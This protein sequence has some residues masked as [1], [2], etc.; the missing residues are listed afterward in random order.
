MNDIVEIPDFRDES[1]SNSEYNLTDII[2]LVPIY[3][4]LKSAYSYEKI[5]IKS[6]EVNSALRMI[7]IIKDYTGIY[8]YACVNQNESEKNLWFGKKECTIGDTVI[9]F[10]FFAFYNYGSYSHM[11]GKDTL[12]NRSYYSESSYISDYFIK[13]KLFDRNGFYL[14][15]EVIS[16]TKTLMVP[17][18]AI[19]LKGLKECKRLNLFNAQKLIDIS[20]LQKCYDWLVLPKSRIDSELIF[21]LKG[22]KDVGTIIMDSDTYIIDA[23]DLDC[24]VVIRSI[25]DDEVVEEVMVTVREY[26]DL[27]DTVT[28][29]DIADLL[30]S[31]SFLKIPQCQVIKN[32]RLRGLKV[33]E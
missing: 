4:P 8:E 15:P 19:S 6:D 26:Y 28:N 29:C 22:L 18:D 13:N 9:N 33:L 5:F 20:T 23:E 14:G 21:S 3:F 10:S 27:I 17:S 30:L 2:G 12:G 7:E 32:K 16:N 11:D 1:W 25:V 24:K 31:D